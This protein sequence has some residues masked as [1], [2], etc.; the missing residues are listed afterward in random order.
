MD[1]INSKE[2]NDF[3]VYCQKTHKIQIK[4]SVVNEYVKYR[5]YMEQQ[6]IKNSGKKEPGDTKCGHGIDCSHVAFNTVKCD[7][8]LN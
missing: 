1:M 2:L 5:N 6:E 3:V 7:E 8:C 4:E